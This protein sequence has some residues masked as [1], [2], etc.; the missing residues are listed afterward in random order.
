MA[1]E[2]VAA[3]GVVEL[4]PAGVVGYGTAADV[5][6]DVVDGELEIAPLPQAALPAA[7]ARAAAAVDVVVEKT[8][9]A[10]EWPCKGCSQR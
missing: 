5:A 10:A 6:V 4:E 2:P 7:A 3:A 1:V 8:D 9:V